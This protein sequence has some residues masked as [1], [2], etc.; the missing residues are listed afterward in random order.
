MSKSNAGLRSRLLEGV[1]V[2]DDHVD[3]ID[4]VRGDGGLMLGVVADEE[5]SAVDLGVQGL[6]AP[7]EHLRKSCQLADVL[8][9]KA[10]LAQRARRA[11]GRDQ[12]DAEASQ[13]LG[14]LHQAA[15][16]G[17]TQQRP[18]YP[19]FRTHSRTPRSRN[20]LMIQEYGICARR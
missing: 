16:V 19:F 8:D 1:E 2:D 9:G 3:R 18:L 4:A 14:K 12:L 6:D 13:S 11:A 15:L 5:Q 10:C 17:H 20:G 7:I